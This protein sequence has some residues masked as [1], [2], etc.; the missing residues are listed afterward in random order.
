MGTLTPWWDKQNSF[1]STI[2]QE[3]SIERKI[4]VY[5]NTHPLLSVCNWFSSDHVCTS[6]CPNIHFNIILSC[7]VKLARNFVPCE[8]ITNQFTRV[9]LSVY[10][11]PRSFY[12]SSLQWRILTSVSLRIV[13][14]IVKQFS[15]KP[16][17]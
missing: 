5:V 17:T 9:L 16:F 1:C 13:N 2:E 12:G 8:V 6:Y 4:I 3:I 14:T 10:Y 7:K 15:R 11:T